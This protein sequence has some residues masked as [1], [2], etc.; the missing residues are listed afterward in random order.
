MRRDLQELESFI[1]PKCQ[2]E[3]VDVPVQKKE[4]SKHLQ[5]LKKG[6]RNQRD[7]LVEEID[8]II[9]KMHSEIDDMD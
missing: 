6:L 5:E 2:E 8:A 7:V 9:Q 3:S 1:L 4:M